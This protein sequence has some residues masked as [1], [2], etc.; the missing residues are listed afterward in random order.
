[1]FAYAS[2]FFGFVKIHMPGF[3]PP[4]GSARANLGVFFLQFVIRNIATDAPF[5]GK[6]RQ[7]TRA[8]AIVFVLGRQKP[9]RANRPPDFRIKFRR[10]LMLGLQ[11]LRIECGLKLR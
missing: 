9:N 7:L 10:A 3:I 6:A 8:T 11:S 4:T 2:S 1:L 5:R